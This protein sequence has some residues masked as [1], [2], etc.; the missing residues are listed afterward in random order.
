MQ[1]YIHLILNVIKP[2]TQVSDILANFDFSGSIDLI[3]YS[4]V[5]V[6]IVIMFSS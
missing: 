5:L 3:Q 2:G 1:I 4:L 6:L